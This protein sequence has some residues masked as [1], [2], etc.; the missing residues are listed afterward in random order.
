MNRKKLEALKLPNG[1]AD[2]VVKGITTVLDEYNLWNCVKMIVADTSVNIGK[3]NGI[4]IQLLRLFA[5][6]DLKE[7]QFIGC[8]HHI[9]DRVLRVVMDNELGEKKSS[10]NI[11]Y[12]FIPELLKNYEK[13][14]AN[15][16]N[17]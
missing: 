7:P 17:G 5:Q 4:I 12:T 9:R 11:E 16:N 14:Q 10:S 6:K 15:F 13:L 3:R 1:K 2:T 8:Q